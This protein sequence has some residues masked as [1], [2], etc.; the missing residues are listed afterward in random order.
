MN[1]IYGTVIGYIYLGEIW[2]HVILCYQLFCNYY[3]WMSA[4]SLHVSLYSSTCLEAL[5]RVEKIL[6]QKLTIYVEDLLD[7]AAL[8]KVFSKV[9]HQ[10]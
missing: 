10:N 1:V 4:G 7:K 5:K 9:V 8:Q 3:C 2:R 6:G